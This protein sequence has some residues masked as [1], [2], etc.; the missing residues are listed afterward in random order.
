MGMTGLKVRLP[1]IS[2]CMIVKN[3]E[4]TL[5]ECLESLRCFDEIILLDNKSTDNTLQ[6]AQ[7][8]NKTY[9]NLKV[10]ES[11]FIGFGALKNLA[12][13]KASNAWVFSIDA[14]EVLDRAVLKEL[15]GLQWSE[16]L[17]LA[18][19]RKN[20]YRGEWIKACGW[21]PDFVNRIFNKTHTQFNTN[22]VHESLEIKKDTQIMRLKNGLLHYA[23]YDMETLL[24]KMQHYSML[25]AEQNLQKKSSMF[26]AILHGGFKFMRD[27][28]F[29]KGFLYGYKGFIISV[30][31]GLGAFFKYAKL[32]ELQN[33]IPKSVSL[34]ITTYNQKERLGLVL[35]SIKELE[36]LPNEVLVADDG[37][38]EDTK[39]LVESYRAD[40]PCI[41]KH[42]WQEDKGFRL[43]AIR[44]KA[45]LAASGEYIIIVDGDMV[46]E[47]HFIK[48]HLRFAKP[49]RFLQGSRV[50]L[51]SLQT[52]DILEQ[53]GGVYKVCGHK[54][55]KSRRCW[56]LS[57]L[58]YA[59][60][61]ISKDFFKTR[62]FIK[63]IR[64]CN[65][66]FYRQDCLDI[67]GFNERFIGWGREDSEFVARFLF[68]G[69]ELRRL[70]FAGIA[71]HL[72]H[73]ENNRAMLESNHK[74]YIQ[75]IKEQKT[76]WKSLK[77]FS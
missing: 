76:Q 4:S 77:R 23:Y 68:N 5:E 69:G 32:Y 12:L 53:G 60:S 10:F 15:G 48:D 66:S 64:G 47:S 19:P 40:F 29:K 62:D 74:I 39:E 31:N 61:A 18:M 34:I 54:S 51:D 20:L 36:I 16:N 43:S 63:G 6:I 2:V 22:L 24:A 59:N 21:Y 14:D 72:Y 71:Y 30:C 56:L 49:K 17:I 3:A 1:K 67:G 41:L 55:F 73:L 58:V 52:K 44:N 57:Y 50:I 13:S 45:I 70:K 38:R 25:W 8:F 46:L 28:C 75:T 37:S 35:D 27:F 11:E 7:E 9:G 42:I 26:K 33:G 65:M